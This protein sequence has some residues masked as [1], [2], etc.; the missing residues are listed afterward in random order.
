MDIPFPDDLLLNGAPS[1]TILFDN[2]TTISIPLLEMAAIIPKPPV[3]I[4]PSNSQDSFLP[5][6]LCLNSKMTYKHN[7][8]Y[9]KGYHGIKN[10]V[11]WFVF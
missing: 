9:H 1:Y 4:S 11:H 8:Q 5:P 3:D 6:F 10:G 2:D 7:G